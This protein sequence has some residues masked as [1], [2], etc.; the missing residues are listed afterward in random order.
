MTPKLAHALLL[1]PFLLL[2][3][4]SSPAK[5]PKTVAHHANAPIDSGSDDLIP[6]LAALHDQM[7]TWHG[8]P[9]EWGGTDESGV[10]CSGF[11]WRTLKDRFNLPMERVTTKELLHMG[12]RVKPQQLRPGDLVFFRI[13]GGMHVGFYDTN[14]NFLHA[15]A[16]QGVMRSSLDNPYWKSAFYQARRLPK[17]YNAQITMNN[18]NLHVAKNR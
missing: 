5:H 9:Y 13:K 16:S 17:E 3:G 12:E 10:D 6:V 18:D 15:S 7:H 11:V 2:A 14:Q 4:C 1:V 8:T